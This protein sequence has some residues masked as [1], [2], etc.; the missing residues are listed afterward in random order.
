MRNAP[1][2]VEVD[3]MQLEDVLRRVEQA[4]DT[5]D[6]ALIRAVFQSYVYVADLVEAKN[7][8]IRRLRRLFFGARTEKTEAVVEGRSS[9][10]RYVCSVA[11]RPIPG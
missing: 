10:P 4:L 2:I 11:P 6:A 1:A 3:N 5:K 8:S 7:T 9:S